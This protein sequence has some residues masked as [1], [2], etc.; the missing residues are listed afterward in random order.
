MKELSIDGIGNEKE[1][2]RIL[3]CFFTTKFFTPSMANCDACDMSL[4]NILKLKK[5]RKKN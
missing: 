5:K 4:E 3:T 1:N 2:Q